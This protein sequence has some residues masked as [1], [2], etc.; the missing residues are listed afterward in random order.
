MSNSALFDVDIACDQCNSEHRIKKA[1][2]IEPLRRL[3]AAIREKN[4]PKAHNSA[5]NTITADSH[6]AFGKTLF[7]QL[8]LHL[9]FTV[10]K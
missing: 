1:R 5:R 3:S 4:P 6:G 7:G 9:H 8:Q 10:Q 2:Q